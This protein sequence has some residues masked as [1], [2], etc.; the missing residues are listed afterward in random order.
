MFHPSV[1]IDFI[2]VTELIQGGVRNSINE[3][4]FCMLHKKKK[5]NEQIQKIY[6]KLD[7]RITGQLHTIY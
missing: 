1:A 3:T 7:R 4:R 5:T 2:T 6:S